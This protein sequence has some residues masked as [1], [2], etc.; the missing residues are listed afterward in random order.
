MDRRKPKFKKEIVLHKDIDHGFIQFE[1]STKRAFDWLIEESDCCSYLN[2][3]RSNN[4]GSLV[5]GVL[6]ISKCYDFDEIFE[7]LS[8]P[9]FEKENNVL[10]IVNDKD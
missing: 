3:T 10:S 2:L 4:S 8:N 7:H 5:M 6:I 9:N 1:T